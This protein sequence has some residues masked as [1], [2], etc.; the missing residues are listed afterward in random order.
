TEEKGGT[1][2][3]DF[4]PLSRREMLTRCGGGIGAIGLAAL[5]GT[6]SRGIADTS[7]PPLSPRPP[8]FKPRAKR[9]IHLWM[10]GGPSQ[11]D[12]FDPKP[13]LKKYAGQRPAST[14]KLTTE[15]Q[16]RGLL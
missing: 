5:L 12:T 2:K 16:T 10:N 14:A 1:M 13:A 6:G 11:V 4:P 15:R 3:T 7:K 9:I 8:H